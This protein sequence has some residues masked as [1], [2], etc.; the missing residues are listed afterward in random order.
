MFDDIL[1]SRPAIGDPIHERD[2]EWYFWD[3][4]WAHAIGPFDTEELAR[5]CLR[6]YI[7]EMLG[8]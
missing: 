1:K 8:E 7:V 4:V 6:K 5:H 3:E 2:G